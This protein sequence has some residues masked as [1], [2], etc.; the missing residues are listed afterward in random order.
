MFRLT[1]SVTGRVNGT[2]SQRGG[3]RPSRWLTHWESER[4]RGRE[5]EREKGGQ[6]SVVVVVVVVVNGYLSP[7]GPSP[8]KKDAQ[9]QDHPVVSSPRMDRDA[10]IGDAI[11]A[12]E[13]LTTTSKSPERVYDQLC[14]DFPEIDDLEL[15][16]LLRYV[17]DCALSDDPSRPRRHG[18]LGLL[19]GDD[20]PADADGEDGTPLSPASPSRLPLTLE[21][22][23][24]TLKERADSSS[25]DS[26][27]TS[28]STTWQA[29]YGVHVFAL[30]LTAP[31]AVRV[32]FGSGLGTIP[33]YL[34]M[35]NEAL[36]S[37][38]F[39]TV[40]AAM[41]L[42]AMK[43]KTTDPALALSVLEGAVLG[44]SS[45][46]VASAV[47]T[48]LLDVSASASASACT[49]ASTRFRIATLRMVAAAS[50]TRRTHAEAALVGP[51]VARRALFELAGPTMDLGTSDPYVL[52]ATS[53]LL[54]HSVWELVQRGTTR[55]RAEFARDLID[56]GLWG[57]LCVAHG[58][59]PSPLPLSAA[60]H[61]KRALVMAC[62]CADE[63][64][65]WAVRVPGFSAA[66]AR[67]GVATDDDAEA[68]ADEGVETVL[69][70]AWS[71]LDDGE[72]PRR[73]HV[74]FLRAAVAAVASG[75]FADAAREAERLALTARLCKALE[76]PGEPSTEGVE[77][78]DVARQVAELRAAVRSRL[79][80]VEVEVEVEAE[81]KEGKGADA[82]RR[83]LAEEEDEEEEEGERK[84]HGRGVGRVARQQ[85]VP[86]VE[87]LRE[88][89][90]LL[91]ELAELA[92]STSR[93][94]KLD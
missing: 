49:M 12:L 80:E 85:S 39:L 71:T 27:S 36:W 60:I 54:E 70:I 42:R 6:R 79:A 3:Y 94:G 21:T 1:R 81:A 13:A 20:R 23:L 33:H 55:Q 69:R 75:G 48:M 24:N 88:V 64:R 10:F 30:A 38:R 47:F 59:S 25:P 65:G 57:K 86:Q 34:G 4:A 11:R 50:L 68:N 29:L 14:Y 62:A 45:R 92:W 63:L 16:Q 18:V 41:L 90:R 76:V 51:D 61:A 17:Y 9:N 91:K 53:V 67:A 93:G 78:D 8:Q 22:V 83:K 35:N 66:W 32:R 74:R 7:M 82:S 5:G 72:A 37:G 46:K 15:Q 19:L 58:A 56:R 44:S 84:D 31:D 43:G 28:T 73:R 77:G 2:I 40:V 87:G 89:D 52:M 26:T